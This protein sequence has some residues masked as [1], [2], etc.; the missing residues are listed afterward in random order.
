MIIEDVR[1]D[2][3]IRQ[4]RVWAGKLFNA[5]KN[6]IAGKKEIPKETTYQF[7]RKSHLY[8]Y[9]L[10]SWTY[11]K[12]SQKKNL[13]NV[14]KLDDKIIDNFRQK[15]NTTNKFMKPD[16]TKKI[17]TRRGKI[18]RRKERRKMELDVAKK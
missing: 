16:W 10:K 4:R 18:D 17:M 12:K 1:L 6:T 15:L 2:Q 5:I 3:E 14:R 8:Q 13:S 11:T 9:T 7:L